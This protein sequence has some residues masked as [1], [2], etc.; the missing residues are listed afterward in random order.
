[1]NASL[2][3]AAP[4]A[5]QA[6]PVDEATIRQQRLDRQLQ[7]MNDDWFV[8]DEN[9]KLVVGRYVRDEALHRRS[10][11]RYSFTDFVRKFATRKGDRKSIGEEW[12]DW[13]ARRSYDRVVFKPDGNVAAD[14]LNLW[15]GFGVEPCPAGDFSA[16]DD[17]LA[18][19]VC[20][21]NWDYS[22]Y[23]VKLL[24]RMVQRPDEAGEVVI[25]LRGKEGVGKSAV[26]LLMRR[27]FGQH[28]MVVSSGKHLVGDF[29]EHLR[30][31]VFLEASEAVFAGDKQAASALKALATENTMVIEAK[32]V[33]ATVVKN[34]LHILMTSNEDWVVDAGPESR[35]YFVL[36]VSDEKRGDRQYFKALFDQLNSDA[37]V[38]GFLHELLNV[39]LSGFDHRD[40]PITA[41]L[42][43][44]REASAHGVTKW[45]FDLISRGGVVR[46]RAGNQPWR[47][48]F[49]TREL[50]ED[51]EEF[52]AG[53]RYERKLAI[54]IFAKE[55]RT[56]LGL[57]GFRRARA[58]S[59]DVPPA[60]QGIPGFELPAKL[61]QFQRR[62]REVAGLLDEDEDQGAVAAGQV[63]GEEAT[64]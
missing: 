41:A 29:N 34:R 3:Q 40:I 42:R 2:E 24:A 63:L 33:N 21:R 49:G 32:G 10:M 16:I 17:H 27:I 48:F 43:D 31:V 52:L 51:Y 61:E 35:R 59:L 55:L 45:A 1:M 5:S 62:V 28:G 4:L 36:D 14:E 60:A 39:D 13:P 7:A 25:V 54:N 20:G 56:K 22:Q 46:T 50:Y 57:H 30:D 37:S 58:S 64:P 18:N 23:L 8:L 26:G 47:S 38:G 9:G 6:A 53:E 44:Q 12:L 11:L 15:T 19:I